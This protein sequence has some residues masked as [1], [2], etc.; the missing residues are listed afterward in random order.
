MSGPQPTLV[1]GIPHCSQDECP[2]FDGKRCRATG[3]RAAGV[4]EPA[5]E[6][7]FEDLEQARRERDDLKARLKRSAAVTVDSP[8]PDDLLDRITPLGACRHARTSL[9]PDPHGNPQTTCIDCGE[10]P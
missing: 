5:V 10:T 3:F 6:Q 4:C 2:L 9:R 8:P 7:A 1:R